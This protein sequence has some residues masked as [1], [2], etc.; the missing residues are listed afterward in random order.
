MEY[1]TFNEAAGRR[2]IS[3]RRGWQMCQSGQLTGT[4]KKKGPGLPGIKN[5]RRSPEAFLRQYSFLWNRLTGRR[6]FPPLFGISAVR[7]GITAWI[8]TWAS[9]L[10]AVLKAPWLPLP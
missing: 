2:N 3:V 5:C 10:P 8:R 7:E 4:L 9:P 1:M 6:G